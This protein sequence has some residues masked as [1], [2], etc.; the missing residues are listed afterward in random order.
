[1]EHFLCECE[2]KLE[3]FNFNIMKAVTIIFVLTNQ[4]FSACR[5]RIFHKNNA[6]NK[7]IVNIRH[8]HNCKKVDITAWFYRGVQ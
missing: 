1:M 7:V 6:F 3:N 4:N 8:F 2:F 5:L